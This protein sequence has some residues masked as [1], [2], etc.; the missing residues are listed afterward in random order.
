MESFQRMRV[1]A[2]TWS[3]AGFFSFLIAFL[4]VATVSVFAILRVKMWLISSLKAHQFSSRM[5]ESV[6]GALKEALKPD[7]IGFIPKHRIRIPSAY[8]HVTLT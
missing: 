1:S 4:R 3:N 2:G 5:T 6:I 8:D 7:V